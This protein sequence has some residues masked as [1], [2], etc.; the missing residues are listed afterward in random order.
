MQLCDYQL[1]YQIMKSRDKSQL[2]GFAY[3]T[4]IQI[5]V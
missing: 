2:L 3:L 1:Y 5:I 4:Q